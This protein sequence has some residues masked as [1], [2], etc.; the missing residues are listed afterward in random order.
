MANNAITEILQVANHKDLR[1]TGGGHAQKGIEYQ[2]HWALMRM[3]E[4]E[5]SGATDYLFLFE[6]LQDIAVFDSSVAPTSIAVFQIKKKDRNEW[7]WVDLTK[8]HQPQDPKK[9]VKRKKKQKSLDVI[10]DSPLGKLYATVKE[11]KNLKC[12]GKFVSNAGCDLPLEA[13]GN[14]ATSLPCALSELSSQYL[15]LLMQGLQTLHAAGETVPALTNLH[16]EKIALPVDEPGTFLVGLVN[17]FLTSRSPRHA[18]QARALVDALLAKVGGLGAKTDTCKDF[19]ELKAQRGFTKSDLNSALGSL[20]QIPD[21]LSHLERCLTALG[22]EGMGFMEVTGIKVAA[23]SASRKQLM[24]TKT[25]DE[26][27]IEEECDK[28]IAANGDPAVLLPYLIN[29]YD[30]ISLNFPNVKRHDLFATLLLRLVK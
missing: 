8:L 12:N 6:A 25:I 17:S 20:E 4:L 11:F 14:A 16:L 30:K 18:G 10:K 1:E 28:W 13:G 24:G 26:M 21:A 7:G 5:G 2:K 22:A 23:T 19:E 3:F 27:Q 15:D 29:A 9:K